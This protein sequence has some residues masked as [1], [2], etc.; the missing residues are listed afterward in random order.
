[1]AVPLLDLLGEQERRAVIA[2]ARRRKFARNEV[3]FH[4][5]DP[6]DTLHL[7]VKGH[8]AIRITTPLGDTATLRVVGPGDH[9]GELAVLAPAARTG[10]VI[11]LDSAETLGVH[12][13]VLEAMRTA[14]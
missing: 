6:G 11:A 3:V 13:D 5:G 12:R 9:F 10:T 1:M 7:I 14:K 4:D 8:F 2:A